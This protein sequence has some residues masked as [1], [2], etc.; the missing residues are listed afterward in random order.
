[1]TLHKVTAEELRKQRLMK[2]V[3][4]S[5]DPVPCPLFNSKIVRQSQIKSLVNCKPSKPPLR[6][7]G[8]KSMLR[9]A[10]LLMAAKAQ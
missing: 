1:M 4:L 5:A 2:E 6:T 10:A 9:T 3:I 8:L 7:L